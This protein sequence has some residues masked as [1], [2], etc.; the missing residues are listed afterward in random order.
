MKKGVNSKIGFLFILPSLIG[1]L[2]FMFIPFLDVVLRSFQ[3]EITRQFVA[4]HNY[5]EIFTNEPFKL[6][7]LNTIK[8][9]VICIPLLI[10]ISLAISVLLDRFV[11]SNFSKNIKIGFL[12][13]FIVPTA[14]VALIWKILFNE[15]GLFNAIIH[16]F[17]AEGLD[18][19]NTKHAFWVL[20][21]SYLW[22]NIG[23]SIVLWLAGIKSINKEMIEAAMIDGATERKIFTKI[24]LPNL[25][26]SFYIITVISL[27]NSFKV[28]RE[29][30]LVTGNYPDK[31]IY[32][33]QNLFNNW[34]I[35][36]SFGKISAASVILAIIISLLIISL[37][38]QWQSEY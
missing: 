7:V 1:I 17:G 33:I 8:F 26:T 31:S 34:F 36:L 11:A 37:Q 13:T 19:M 22:R 21:L 25:K 30:Y 2:I 23:Y 15:K 27:I 9:I 4:F 32:M 12:L 29:V 16:K 6:A 20:I 14:S 18:W 5:K 38:K 10:V 35:D 3:D 24:T 28:F